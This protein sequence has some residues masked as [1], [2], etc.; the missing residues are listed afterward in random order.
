MIK[1]IPL[2]LFTLKGDYCFLF[3]LSSFSILF[4]LFG[5]YG[6]QIFVYLFF[7]QNRTKLNF[8]SQAT[9]SLK[10]KFYRKKLLLFNSD[11]VDLLGYKNIPIL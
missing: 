9:N 7:A 1:F 8:Y 3:K 2:P 4:V 6:Y 10:S 11:M 5:F